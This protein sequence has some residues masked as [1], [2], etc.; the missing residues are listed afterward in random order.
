MLCFT[1]A[2]VM[3]CGAAEATGLL[4]CAFIFFHKLS[5]FTPLIHTGLP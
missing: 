3:E 4:I 2:G 5:S 1:Y